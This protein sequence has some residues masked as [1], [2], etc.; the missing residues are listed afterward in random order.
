MKFQEKNYTLLAQDS[1][2]EGVFHMQGQT[3]ISG[4]I[5]GELFMKEASPLTIELKGKID[6]LIQCQDLEIYGQVDGEIKAT[7]KVTLYASAKVNGQILA[8]NL[9][10]YPGA[11]LNIVGKTLN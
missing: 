6:G 9:K 2:L 4:N 5:K 7:G 3:H 10:I 11:V 1:T 8:E